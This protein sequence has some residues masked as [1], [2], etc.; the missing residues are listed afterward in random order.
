MNEMAGFAL[1]FGALNA[2]MLLCLIIAIIL[3]RNGGDD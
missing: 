3:W 2:L 1:I